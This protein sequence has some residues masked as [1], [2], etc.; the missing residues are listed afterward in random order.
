VKV[1]RLL[2]LLPLLAVGQG[3]GPGPG[4]NSYAASS[5]SLTMTITFPSSANVN[6]TTIGAVDWS[7]FA[8]GSTASDYASGAGNTVIGGIY[9]TN[10]SSA[11]SGDARSFSWTNGTNVPTQTGENHG[12]YNINAGSGFTVTFPADTNPRTGYVYLGV[13]EQT[14][15]A[16]ITASLSDSSAP[17]VS[18]S[19]TLTGTNDGYVYFTWQ[20]ASAS[21]HLTV[22]FYNNTA[23][24]GNV[25]LQAAAINSQ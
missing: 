5:G 9:G 12:V 3:M 19:A 14:T 16:T 22:S 15:A 21:Q 8:T 13:Y 1:L 11:Y 7:A 20:A 18:N 4:V 25:S 24:P 10:T 6:L 17:T 23:S 2:L